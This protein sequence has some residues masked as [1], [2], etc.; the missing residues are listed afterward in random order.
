MLDNVQNFSSATFMVGILQTGPYFTQ[1]AHFLHNHWSD[2]ADILQQACITNTYHWSKFQVNSIFQ[3]WDFANY[4]I[5][6][7]FSV[8][9]K[10]LYYV[11]STL[12]KE[13]STQQT[14]LR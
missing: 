10:L 13:D 14:I 8:S 4:Q 3:S 11:W 1:N 9:Y 2:F 5:V 12:E 7:V 6:F